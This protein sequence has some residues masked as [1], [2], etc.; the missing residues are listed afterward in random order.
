MTTREKIIKV[1][2]DLCMDEMEDM[3]AA[4]RIAALSD[5]E[6]VDELIGIAYYFH[7]EYNES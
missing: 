3:G 1:I 2:Q 6:L 5:D 7:N 4:F